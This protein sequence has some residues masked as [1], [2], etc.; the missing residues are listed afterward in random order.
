MFTIEG[1]YTKAKVMIDELDETTISQIY[2]MVN[3]PSSTNP[4]SIMPDSHA[5]AGCVVGFTMEIGNSIVPNWVGV[6][7]SC[8]MTSFNVG[9]R[10]FESMTMKEFDEEVRKVIPF[11]TNTRS[12]VSQISFDY[13]HLNEKLRQFCLKFNEKL[14]KDELLSLCKG[15]GITDPDTIEKIYENTYQGGNH[16]LDDDVMT[17]LSTL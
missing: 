6:D 5:G 10:L 17:L 12:K 2:G 13:K 7:L 4:I 9:K 16:K 14:K 3:H 1:K 11:G 8:N 15:V